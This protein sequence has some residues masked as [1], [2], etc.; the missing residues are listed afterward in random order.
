MTHHSRSRNAFTLIEMILAVTIISL[1]LSSVAVALH[2]MF[3]VDAQLRKDLAYSV[4][5]P[6]LSL[7]VRQDA[8]ESN[9][10]VITNVQE[11]SSVL[12]LA[13]GDNQFV[14]YQ[15]NAS[16]IVR[17]VYRD[18]EELRHEVYSLEAAAVRW[19]FDEQTRLLRLRIERNLG[20]IKD[21][22]DALHVDL[23][24][25]VVGLNEFDSSS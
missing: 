8:H 22:K 7:Q 13:Q 24:E 12:T 11:G 20:E 15:T 6:R 18:E 23:I 3:R 1:V 5:L 16:G 9:S 4:L 19:D 21:A 2:L 25:A 17:S 10:T 14:R